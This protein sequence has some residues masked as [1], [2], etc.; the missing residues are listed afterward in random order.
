MLKQLDFCVG[1]LRLIF[2][3]VGS[4]IINNFSIIITENLIISRQMRKYS[5]LKETAVFSKCSKCTRKLL[6]IEGDMPLKRSNL[7]TFVWPAGKSI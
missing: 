1:F 2:V 5:K 6:K 4:L 7:Q 3:Y